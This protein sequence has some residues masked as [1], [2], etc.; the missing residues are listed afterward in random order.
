MLIMLNWLLGIPPACLS[1][2]KLY[3]L[4]M[5]DLVWTKGGWIYGTATSVMKVLSANT[6][7]FT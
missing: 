5:V 1:Q 7:Q 3:I 6:D 2:V 4:L